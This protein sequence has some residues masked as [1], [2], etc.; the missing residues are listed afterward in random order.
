MLSGG[1]DSTSVAATAAR[2]RP[3]EVIRTY[4]SVP[5]PGWTGPIEPGV[6][7]D[8]SDLVRDLAAWY[9]NLRPALISE[10]A[11][12]LLSSHDA[13]FAAGSPPPRNP[14]NE[15]WMTEVHRRAAAEGVSTLL[16]GARGNAF[17]SADDPFWIAALLSRGRFRRA[18]EEVAALIA[19]PGSPGPGAAARQLAHQLVP[20]AAWRLAK[21]V[22]ARRAGLSADLEMRFAGPGIEH[23]VRRH[24][25]DLGPVPRG[26]MRGTLFE[27]VTAS[28]LISESGAVRDALTG[29][30]RSDPTG[31]IRVIALCATQPPW[32]RRREGRTRV[33]VRDA[34]ADRL[35]S[36]IAERTRRGFQLP[37]WLDQFT[38]RRQELVDE[39]A[40]A[41]EHAGCRELLD[42][43]AMDAALRDWPDREHASAQLAR[44][45]VVYRYNLMRALFMGRYLRF[46]DAHATQ[47]AVMPESANASR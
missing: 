3:R 14:C 43:D 8:E 18:G 21:R 22:R 27:L 31:D 25:G 33:V 17:F 9:P 47:R 1:L 19:S 42:L 35:P 7:G 15:L 2:L 5:P 36:S 39:L 16:T 26:S 32:A 29:V 28:G 10:Y 13:R 41:R 38:R 30:R 6:D 4:T 12:S 45:T 11:G 40:A 24:A 46:F 37:D 34:M 20:H 44:T 23:V